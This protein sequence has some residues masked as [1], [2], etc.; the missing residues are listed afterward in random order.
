MGLCRKTKK[1]TRKTYHAAA[2]R[3]FH[4]GAGKQGGSLSASIAPSR[5]FCKAEQKRCNVFRRN[6]FMQVNQMR[7]RLERLQ[8]QSHKLQDVGS[9]P[10]PATNSD[11][12]Q[13]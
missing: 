4:P 2:R 5:G 7:D 10:T 6:A 11:V 9:N 3:G 12:A 13:W 1:V 8:R